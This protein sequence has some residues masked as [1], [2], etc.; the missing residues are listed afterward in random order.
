MLYKLW[1]LI[2]LISKSRSV[3]YDQCN[4][5][6]LSVLKITYISNPYTNKI[7]LWLKINT[8]ILY[9]YISHMFQISMEC[10]DLL[11]DTSSSVRTSKLHRGDH[12][13]VMSVLIW[14]STARSTGIVDS[15]TT[16]A[17]V[18]WTQQISE[19]IFHI[20]PKP[21]FIG[22]LL[23]AFVE[24]KICTFNMLV[25]VISAVVNIEYSTKQKNADD[26]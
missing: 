18:V 16:P 8:E 9:I 7:L 19:C 14:I 3:Q 2:L 5:G 10:S 6:M 17:R 21:P 4:E 26:S 11:T 1:H 13:T 25:V 15:F 12:C 24:F 22:C 23:Y 20:C